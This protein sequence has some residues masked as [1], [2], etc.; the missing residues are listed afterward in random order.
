MAKP[1][2]KNVPNLAQLVI[3][4]PILDSAFA[5][6]GE[7]VEDVQN[8]AQNSPLDKTANK[9]VAVFGIIQRCVTHR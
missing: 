3:V 4:M 7:E 1:V 9:N 8:I 2:K 5:L 6:L